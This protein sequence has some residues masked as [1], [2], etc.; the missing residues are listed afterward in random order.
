M[1]FA[2]LT[3]AGVQRLGLQGVR[4]RGFW[5]EDAV[6]FTVAQTWSR[7]VSSRGIVTKEAETFRGPVRGR[8]GTGGPSQPW[9]VL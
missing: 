4:H 2:S 9:F 8:Q 5:E 1:V 7:P 3:G 6:G